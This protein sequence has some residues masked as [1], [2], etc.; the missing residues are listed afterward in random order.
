SGALVAEI[1]AQVRAAV[2]PGVTTQ[3][4]DALVEEALAGAG[5]SS[6]FKGY[7]GF[8]A[9]ICASV[10]EEVVHGIPGRRVLREG[11]IISVDIGAIVEG[12]HGDSAWTYPVGEVA[13][14]ALELL[15]VGEA[16]LHAAIRR[17]LTGN[18]LS[19]VSHAVQEYVEATGFS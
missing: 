3:A 12:Y 11:D 2:R 17:A 4:L 6:S 9:N 8:P 5:A 19:D 10:N 18:R 14:E 7:Q 15:R 1:H 13:P 16:S